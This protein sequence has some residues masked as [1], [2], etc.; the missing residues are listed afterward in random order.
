MPRRYRKSNPT[1]HLIILSSLIGLAIVGA[2][3]AANTEPL[4][5][6]MKY[7]LFTF[8]T[9]L[10]IAASVFAIW[11]IIAY[12][13]SRQR[14]TNFASLRAH[15]VD[16]MTGKEFEIFLEHLLTARGFKVKNVY[17]SND[18]GVDLVAKKNKDTYSIQ[19]KRY[20]QRKKVDRRAITDAI[21]G[22][23]YRDCTKAM[24]ITNSY[25]TKAAKEYGG[26]TGCILIDRDI[27]AEWIHRLDSQA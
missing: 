25:F 24:A 8:L 16:N 6:I 22:M 11:R 18:G 15:N 2:Q 3:F 20:N 7:A 19:A 4:A 14:A 21:A 1:Q 26:K 13:T 10:V 23:K 9:L 27:L 17:H 5:D 12:F